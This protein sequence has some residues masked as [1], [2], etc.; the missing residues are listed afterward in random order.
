MLIVIA[1]ISVMVAVPVAINVMAVGQTTTSQEAA[2]VIQAKQAAAAGVSDYIN[3]LQAYNLANPTLSYTQ[4]CSPLVTSFGC[5]STTDPGNPAFVPSGS[6]TNGWYPP[7]N[8]VTMPAA[9]N[10]GASYR[11]VVSPPDSS[12]PQHITVFSIGQAGTQHGQHATSTDEAA[13]TVCTGGCLLPSTAATCIPIP[14]NAVSATIVAYGASGGAG[15]PSGSATA[16]G[17]SGALITTTV[18]VTHDDILDLIPGQSGKPGNFHFLDALNLFPGAGGHGGLQALSCPLNPPHKPAD[19][20]GGNGDIPGGLVDLSTNGGGGGGGASAVYDATADSMLA[21]AGGGGGGGG[22]GTI[23]GF[24]G[25]GL[26]LGSDPPTAGGT[27]GKPPQPGSS[28]TGINVLNL[29]LLTLSISAGGPGGTWVAG[30]S[31]T[32]AAGT[33]G[34]ECGQYGISVPLAGLINGGGGGGGGGYSAAGSGGGG[35]GATGPLSACLSLLGAK[36]L[37]TGT[38]LAGAAGSGA[39]GGAGTSYPTASCGANSTFGTPAQYAA[40]DP[41]GV[42]QIGITFYAGNCGAT[43]LTTVT[44]IIRAASPPL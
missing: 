17:G 42:G 43:P 6:A 9:T 13:L 29:G 18:P 27:G 20:S 38:L 35:G 19:L 2:I 11:Y 22:P 3:H 10:G 40:G 24:S 23:L 36:I 25:L 30:G 4:Y 44:G 37:C 33:P 7:S 14:H 32:C 34:Q 8:G 12:V 16:S 21:V 26:L 1:L 41:T 28:T 5:S 15:S 39:G 31:T